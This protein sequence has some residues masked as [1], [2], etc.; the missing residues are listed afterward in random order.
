MKLIMLGA[1]Q[2]STSLAILERLTVSQER[3]P[4]AL[5]RLADYVPE[6]MIISTCN[7]VEIYALVND[8]TQGLCALQEFLQD[9]QG[10]SPH[11]LE[12]ALSRYSEEAVVRH[13]FRL[14]AGL[15][16]MVL[17]DD[18]IDVL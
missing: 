5:H 6:G 9:Y 12:S 15:D 10:I 7:R 11:S 18:Q 3:L 2:R 13:L 17:G 16:S 8:A 4:H 1:H 14:A